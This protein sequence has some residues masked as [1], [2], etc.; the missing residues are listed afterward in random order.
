[1][2]YERWLRL[3][4]AWHFASNADTFDAL[5]RAYSAEGRHYHGVAH[6]DACL[7]HVD[8]CAERMQHPRE[9]EL[10][11][12]FHDAVYAPLSG[13]NE[14]R[15]ADW[16]TAFLAENA[17]DP[18]AIER[19]RALIITTVHN[20]PAHTHDESLLLDIDLAILGTPPEVYANFESGVRKEYRMVPAPI[21][22]S[23]RSEILQGFLDRSRIYANEPFVS[24]YEGQARENLA[25]AIASLAGKRR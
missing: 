25:H 6:V 23:K 12:W 18:A 3:M 21:Y 1:M 11:L 19:V 22:R 13:D 5:L 7:R 8:R 15:S 24:E 2:N 20:A 17:A 4:E 10:A 9:V 14:R 16:A